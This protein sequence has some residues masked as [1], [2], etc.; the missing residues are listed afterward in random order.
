MKQQ[1]VPKSKIYLDES[2]FQDLVRFYV[3][4]NNLAPLAAK[5]YAYLV[6]DFDRE[7][8]TFDEFVEV[9]HASKSSVSSSL[10]LL[11]NQHLIVDINKIDERR[12]YFVLNREYMR[13]HFE[14][15]I[16]KLEKELEITGNLREFYQ[17]KNGTDN[18]DFEVYSNLLKRN[19]SN[20]Q[21]TLKE[22]LENEK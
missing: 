11:L 15:I 7:G 13:T 5:I 12:R 18:S 1:T 10:H 22:L 17:R 3:D 9:F 21:Y 16:L 8:V 20:I 19:I 4:H 6:F 2:I 14:N